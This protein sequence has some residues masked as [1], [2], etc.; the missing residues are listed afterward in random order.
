M[1]SATS[2]RCAS[3]YESSWC[4]RTSSCSIEPG[5]LVGPFGTDARAGERLRH[6]ALGVREPRLLL[7]Q[8]FGRRRSLT[9]APSR[10]R[11]RGAARRS[12]PRRGHSVVGEDHVDS[13]LDAASATTSIAAAL[14]STRNTSASPARSRSA[15]S[16]PLLK[17]S[18]RRTTSARARPQG[19]HAGGRGSPRAPSRR[20]RRGRRPARPAAAEHGLDNLDARLISRQ[21]RSAHALGRASAPRT[22]VTTTR[23]ERRARYARGIPRRVRAPA[24]HPPPGSARRSPPEGAPRRFPRRPRGRARARRRRRAGVDVRD[25][26]VAGEAP[27]AAPAARPSPRPRARRPRG[28]PTP[29]GCRSARS[30]RRLSSVGGTSTTTRAPAARRVPSRRRRR[31]GRAA[32]SRAT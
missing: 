20:T 7:A 19:A 17:V 30:S 25:E 5:E 24:T 27:A 16:V 3:V 11:R 32:R 12:R 14:I 15:R 22:P 2:N 9:P 31:R 28:S 1:C 4:S 18:E 10:R 26:R 21:R 8:R 23:S 13:L 29:R 6:E